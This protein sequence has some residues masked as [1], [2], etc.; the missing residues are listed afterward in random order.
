MEKHSLGRGLKIVDFR[1]ALYPRPN[2]PCTFEKPLIKRFFAYN[3]CACHRTLLTYPNKPGMLLG[4][5]GVLSLRGNSEEAVELIERGLP[6][7][8]NEKQKSTMRAVL[9]FLYL[10]CG[11]TEKAAMLA[12]ALPHIRESRE[13]IQPLTAKGLMI[14]RSMRR[15]KIF[16]WA[17]KM[18][19]LPFVFSSTNS[20]FHKRY[21]DFR[22]E[23]SS[24][25]TGKTGLFRRLEIR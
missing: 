18:K 8:I 11:K 17:V 23:K 20:K 21:R 14:M 10:K 1:T 25:F 6:L 2:T 13:V 16:Y 3:G 7:S 19:S 9:C 15:S 22:P 24:V 12:S 5:A 4:L